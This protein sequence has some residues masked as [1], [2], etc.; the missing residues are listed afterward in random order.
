MKK[1]LKAFHPIIVIEINDN[2]DEIT[3]FLLKVGY[4]F[5]YNQHLKEID[6]TEKNDIPNLFTSKYQLMI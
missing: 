1:F 5:F 6:I 4:Q 3:K 2:F